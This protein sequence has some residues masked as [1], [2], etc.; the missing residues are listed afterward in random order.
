MYNH[1]VAPGKWSLFASATV[2]SFRWVR[3]DLA[4]SAWIPLSPNEMLKVDELDPA[5]Q[6]P[7]TVTVFP[8]A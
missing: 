6:F 4:G 3:Y 1:P 5:L 8:T 2:A 7:E